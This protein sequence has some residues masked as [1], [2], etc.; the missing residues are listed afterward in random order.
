VTRPWPLLQRSK[1]G[2]LEAVTCPGCGDGAV[3]GGD[4][5]LRGWIDGHLPRCKPEAY[6]Q[7]RTTGKLDGAATA[8]KGGS[9]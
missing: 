1:K 9:S 6:V 5:Y 7:Y 8:P 4:S 3:G 2:H